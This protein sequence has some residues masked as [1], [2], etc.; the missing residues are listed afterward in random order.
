MSDANVPVNVTVT[1]SDKPQ[2]INWVKVEIIAEST[3]TANAAPIRRNIATVQSTQAFLLQP[4]ASQTV[5]LNLAMNIGAAAAATEDFAHN[6]IMSAA[7]NIVS[8]IAQAAEA[9]DTRQ[10]KYTIIASA[11]IANIT[12]GPSVS[13]PIQVMKLGSI[14]TGTSL[15]V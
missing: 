6:P 2:T 12:L 15:N 11:D 7:A 1:T 13:Q 3:P 10:Y 9:M 8:G 5:Q 4:G 14:G